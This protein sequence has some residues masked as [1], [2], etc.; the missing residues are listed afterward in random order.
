MNE[1]S[2]DDIDDMSGFESVQVRRTSR[3]NFADLPNELILL[4][5][6]YIFDQRD[7]CRFIRVSRKIRALLSDVLFR[8]NIEYQG[9]SALP[10]AVRYDR[11]EAV[12]RFLRLHAD[13]NTTRG[14]SHRGLNL[15]PIYIAV[16]TQ[17]L[18]IVKILVKEGAQLGKT[19]R[20]CSFA[21]LA[22]A[23]QK[24]N[25]TIAR[26]LINQIQDL[27]EPI[28][29][30]L[31]PL[32]FAC[33]KRHFEVFQ[34]LLDKGATPDVPIK[35]FRELLTRRTF[36]S[37]D[38]TTTPLECSAFCSIMASR[39]QEINSKWER[40]IPTPGYDICS[41]SQASRD[42]CPETGRMIM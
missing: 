31:T 20:L 17:N 15:P 5:A 11:V 35:Q 42:T 29:H 21:P 38:W 9:S 18:R 34:C 36:T 12:F 13:I 1:D 7:L 6:E 2:W 30:D 24:G 27:D 3:C 19:S 41:S 23:I 32:A 39:R 14:G 37:T 25:T 16:A 33:E 10:W 22:I 4:I 26:V 8:R 40:L 28:I